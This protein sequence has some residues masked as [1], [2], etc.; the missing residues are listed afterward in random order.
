MWPLAVIIGIIGLY[1]VFFIVKKVTNSP[2][3]DNFVKDIAEPEEITLTPD[4]RIKD[5]SA[6]K[7]A[8]QKDQK[9]IDKQIEADKKESAKIG[10]YLAKSNPVAKTEDP[11]KEE[12][13]KKE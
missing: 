2:W 6:A 9:S 1:V 3:V 8:L 5:S 7:K 4:D 13:V 10:D 12:T 11:G